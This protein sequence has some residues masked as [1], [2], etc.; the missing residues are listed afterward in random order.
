MLWVMAMQ[1]IT[2]TLNYLLKDDREQIQKEML[3]KLIHK[4]MM[5]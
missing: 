3:E 5:L 4:L 1:T 2:R